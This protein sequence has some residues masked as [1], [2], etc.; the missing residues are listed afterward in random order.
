MSLA[1]YTFSIIIIA[2]A[3]YFW[4]EILYKYGG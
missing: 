1:I 3:I 2:L 4:F